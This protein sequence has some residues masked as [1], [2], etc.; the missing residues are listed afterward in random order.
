MKIIKKILP[1]KVYLPIIRVDDRLIHGQVVVGWGEKLQLQR[2]VLA[3]DSVAWDEMLVELYSSLIP[4]EIEGA[5]LPIKD[6]VNYLRSRP[7]SGMQMIVTENADD[8]VRLLEA[9]LKVSKVIIG[10]MHYIE[11][12]K[13]LLSYVFVNQE[14][15]E[16]LKKLMAFGIAVECQDLPGNPAYKL[17][18]KLLRI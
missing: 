12:C 7:F 17:T 18:E 4:P 3:S 16:A 14:R 15:V 2:M 9:G 5:I 1:D 10:G 11:G 13:R 6:T 8:A